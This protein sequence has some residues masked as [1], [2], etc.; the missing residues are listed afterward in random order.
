MSLMTENGLLTGPHCEPDDGELVLG[1][2]LE[3]DSGEWACFRPSFRAWWRSVGKTKKKST[4]QLRA[5]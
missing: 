3:P 1:P 5:I 4:I 2:S